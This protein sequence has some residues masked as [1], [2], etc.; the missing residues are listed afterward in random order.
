MAAADLLDAVLAFS[1]GYFVYHRWKSTSSKWVW[2]PG[3]CWFTLRLVHLWYAQSVLSRLTGARPAIFWELSG[4]SG[5]P[6][7]ESLETWSGYT[8]VLVRT[9]F[10]STGAVCCSRVGMFSRLPHL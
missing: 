6:D 2:V 5:L 10:Y 8:I 7:Y 3:V 9:V 1:L 4:D